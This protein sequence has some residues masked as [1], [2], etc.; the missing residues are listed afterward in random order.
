MHPVKLA[1][2]I[3]FACGVLVCLSTADTALAMPGMGPA[4]TKNS[5][6][7]LDTNTDGTISSEEFFKAFT[8]MKEGAFAVIDKD[9]SGSVT[10]EEWNAFFSSHA[11]T[12]AHGNGTMP[13][14]KAAP[15]S[16]STGKTA[17]PLI[18]PPKQ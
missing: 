17:P 1:C 9:G 2:T 7:A 14:G 11:Q 12:A 5:F 3:L 18:M 13:A 8:T 10:E 6:A 15:G 4:G 16:N